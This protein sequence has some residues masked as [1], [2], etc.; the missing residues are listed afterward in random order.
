MKTFICDF[1]SYTKYIYL[2]MSVYGLYTPTKLVYFIVYGF[3]YFRFKN[4]DYQRNYANP[5]VKN[6]KDVV[7]LKQNFTR[8]ATNVGSSHET[9]HGVGFDFHTH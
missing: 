2:F 7:V 1:Y 3:M 4:I 6:S 9:P 5:E 8:L